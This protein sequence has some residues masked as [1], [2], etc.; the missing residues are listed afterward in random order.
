MNGTSCD[1]KDVISKW[2]RQKQETGTLQTTAASTVSDSMRARVFHGWE[3]ILRQSTSE[4]PE[5]QSLVC[6]QKKR[7][8][9]QSRLLIERAKFAPHVTVSVGIS[10]EGKGGLHFAEEKQRSMQITT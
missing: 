4:Q 1:F 5:Q 3:G 9:P 2:T 8:V 10:F 7:R 6:W